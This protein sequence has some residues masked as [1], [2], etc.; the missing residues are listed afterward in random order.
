MPWSL[1]WS[2]RIWRPRPRSC[3]AMATDIPYDLKGKRVWVAGHRGLVGGAL[4]RRLAAE[5]CELVTIDRGK[6]DLRRQAEVEAWMAD[7]RPQ[8][9]F[10]AAAKVGGILAND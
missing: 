4:M 3:G 9:V 6:V 10:L 7:T 1:K 8:A 2:A 5:D